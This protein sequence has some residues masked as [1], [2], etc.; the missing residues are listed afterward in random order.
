MPDPAEI[1]GSN[2]PAY[3]PSEPFDANGRPNRSNVRRWI[4]VRI[5]RRR[6]AVEGRACGCLLPRKI[7]EQGDSESNQPAA[8]IGDEHPD[9]TGDEGQGPDAQEPKHDGSVSLGLKRH[10]FPHGHPFVRGL[11]AR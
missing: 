1:P 4:E 3:Y 9:S 7:Q 8:W 2:K 5:L 6:A 10:A 11:Q